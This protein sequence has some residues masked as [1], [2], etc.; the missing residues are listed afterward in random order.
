MQYA[1]LIYG[2]EADAEKAPPAAREAILRDFDAFTVSILKA[3]KLRGGEALQPTPTAT[4]VRFKDGRLVTTDGPFG[5]T[6]EQLGGF[7]LIDA[8]NLDDALEIASRVPSVRAGGTVE[9][10]PVLTVPRP[11]QGD[12]GEVP[13]LEVSRRFEAPPS[14][15]F[16]AWLSGQWA[17]WVAPP[18]STCEVVTLE[19]R[20]GGSYRL[21]MAMPDGRSVFIDGKFRELARPARLVMTWT[22]SYNGHE[23]LLTVFLRADGKDTIMS[24]RHE[25]FADAEQREGYQV[26][27]TGPGGAFDKLAESLAHRARS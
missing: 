9:I 19:Q 22:G 11:A 2:N 21:K 24:L 26:G 8:S 13:P 16:D 17:E 18:G 25:R 10:R 20:V 12:A 6:K 5:Q 27:W 15:V 1:L 7:Y 14:T 23:T 3:G 4:S